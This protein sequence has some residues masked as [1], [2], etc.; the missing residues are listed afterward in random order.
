VRW[1]PQ[2]SSRMS[3]RNYRAVVDMGAEWFIRST[4]VVILLVIA[5]FF[6]QMAST[7]LPLFKEPRISLAEVESAVATPVV[8]EIPRAVRDTGSDSPPL[9][10]TSD[11]SITGFEDGIVHGFLR[12]SAHSGADLSA[13]SGAVTSFSIAT[14]LPSISYASTIANGGY[15]AL[16]S[17]DGFFQLG[18][19][20]ESDSAKLFPPVKI[21]RHDEVL[22]TP[23]KRS[24]LLLAGDKI[25]HVHLEASEGGLIAVP[26]L[27]YRLD[28]PALV[29]SNVGLTRHFVV[30]DGESRFSLYKLG[31]AKS[32]ATY[33]AGAS[34]S[35]VEKIE[36]NGP[37]HVDVFR[38]NGALERYRID[39]FLN[40]LDVGDLLLPKHYEGYS[41][42]TNTWQPE[43]IAEGVEP[44]Y[45]FLPLL[46]GT[47]SSAFFALILSLPVALGAAVYVGYFMT[48]AY[49]EIIKPVIEMLAAFPGVVIAGLAMLWLAPRLQEFVAELIGMFVMIPVTVSVLAMLLGSRVRSRPGR[50]FSRRLP[51]LLVP[52]LSGALYGGAWL[53]SFVD[54][55]FFGGSLV[56]WLAVNRGVSVSY[57]NG[58]LV[59][60]ALSVATFPVIFSLA[61][62]A[63]FSSPNSAAAGSLALGASPWQ[64]FVDG[65]LP[66]AASG[67]VAALMLGLS[68]AIGETM[69]LLL[70]S[71]N[72]PLLT[73]SPLEGI[74]SVAATL[75]IELPEAAVGSSHFRVLFL[76][77]LMLF[78]LTF[79]INTIAQLVKRR[80][81]HRYGVSA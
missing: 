47:L 74:R 39:N 1:R 79:A 45:S 5:G 50:Y 61:E 28:G 63:I 58:L 73:V 72:M 31:Q 62:E 52:I 21:P 13:A 42:V 75:A 68:R 8:S 44:K 4:S 70:L 12:T 46:W 78:L 55:H 25:H 77:A 43:G 29:V 20:N 65:V 32:R 7:A 49:R 54:A 66:Y 11:L 37:G 15:V 48:P 41:E 67:I 71:G 30:A 56:G 38:V 81:H 51:L 23:G 2:G 24:W 59:G 53:G 19:I 26:L 3:V 34:L 22:S 17:A 27:E 36:W 18:K 40:T 9:L 69:I 10:V 16:F 64:S 57:F 60:L 76:A 35:Q 6:L 14:G 33:S 80:W